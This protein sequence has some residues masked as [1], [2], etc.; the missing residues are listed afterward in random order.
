VIICKAG[1]CDARGACS[2][3]SAK[4]VSR[5]DAELAISRM[6]NGGDFPLTLPK[7]MRIWVVVFVRV[8]RCDERMKG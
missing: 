1:G 7:V 5:D 2:I 3:T 4:L 8:V 6:E